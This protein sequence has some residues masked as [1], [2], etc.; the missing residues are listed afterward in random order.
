M[1]ACATMWSIAGIFIKLIPWNALTIAGFRSLIA[2]MVVLIFMKFTK[3]K[4]KV[5]RS[6]LIGALFVGS[7]FFAFVSANKLTTAANAI[8]LQ[9][10]SPVFILIISALVYH[11]QFFKAD[12]LTVVL[13]LFG[14]SLFFFDRLGAGNLLG[15]CIAVFAGLLM[16]GMYVTT[17]QMDD[18][19]RMSAILFGH[20]MTA[21]IGVP[22]A[23][24]FPTP[25][26]AGS[27]LS[28]LTLGILQLGIPYILYGLAVK[29]C[30]PLACSLVGAIEPLLNPVWVWIFY[31]EAPGIYALFGGIIVI[32][33]VTVWCVWRDR[34]LASHRVND[35]SKIS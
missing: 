31:G 32:G 23:F 6:S 22:T 35:V 25:V 3:R 4:I 11:Q 14:I 1:A 17:G 5:S 20:V 26:S 18:D 9:F 21:L 15:N 34:F 13:T 24:L 19:S 12:L 30:P 2:A 27:V 29:N 28:V 16:A 8:V 10:T 7:T 33:A